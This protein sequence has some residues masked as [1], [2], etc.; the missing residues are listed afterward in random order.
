MRVPCCRHAVQELLTRWD[1]FDPTSKELACCI[2]RSSSDYLVL[3][4]GP[5][6]QSKGHD[7][8]K[9]FHRANAFCGWCYDAGFGHEFVMS[10]V[11]GGSR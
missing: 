8:L 10:E 9:S 6:V 3:Q 2:A 4:Q 5:S 11:A 7:V 1:A